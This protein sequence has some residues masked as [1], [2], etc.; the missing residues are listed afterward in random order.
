MPGI[1]SSSE[2]QVMA[3]VQEMLSVAADAQLQGPS[4]GIDARNL[5]DALDTMLRLAFVLGNFDD[6]GSA[7]GHDAEA[8]ETMDDP[9]HLARNAFDHAVRSRLDSWLANIRWQLE[10]G[11]LTPAPLRTMVSS[12]ATGIG[13]DAA[14]PPLGRS[15]AHPATAQEPLDANVLPQDPLGDLQPTRSSA[16]TSELAAREH[17]ALLLRTLEHQLTTISLV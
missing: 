14:S 8:F 5:V 4:A 16:S 1:I 3:G 2:L 13:L 12:V 7:P 17:V 10:P 6:T 11:Q 9:A 15:G